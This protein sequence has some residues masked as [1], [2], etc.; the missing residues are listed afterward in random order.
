MAEL[1]AKVSWWIV[2]RSEWSLVLE[3]VETYEI[4]SQRK[5]TNER[6]WGVNRS[7]QISLKKTYL[8]LNTGTAEEYM[9]LQ[10][11]LI[12]IRDVSY[13]FPLNLSVC[14]IVCLSVWLFVCLSDCLSGATPR[15]WTSNQCCLKV[16]SGNIGILTE[17]E[18]N[19]E[20]LNEPPGFFDNT[21]VNDVW[22]EMGGELGAMTVNRH[23]Q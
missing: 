20:V 4:W 6:S 13:L 1:S 2:W 5:Q 7:N 18:R 3:E 10:P 21:R 14:L 9:L 11:M 12:H 22:R 23:R 17:A 19:A 8:W 15:R 16:L